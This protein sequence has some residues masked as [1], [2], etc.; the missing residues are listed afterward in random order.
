MQKVSKK[1]DQISIGESV[2]RQIELSEDLIDQYITIS[3]DSSEIHQCP[4]AAEKAGFSGRVVHGTLISSFFSA[5]IG[6]ELPGHN[7]LL[8]E[9]K[10]K[11][12]SPAVVG[13]IISVE[14]LVKDKH[15]SVE[16]VSLKLNATRADGQKICSGEA[17]VKIRPL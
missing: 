2:S 9:I 16:C 3:E 1:I 11:F 15:L 6:T 10:C 14:A 5:L 12:H 17:L 7:A 13:D 8:L 4:K